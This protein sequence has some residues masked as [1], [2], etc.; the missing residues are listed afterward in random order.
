VREMSE[1]AAERADTVL[2]V[3]PIPDNE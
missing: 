2:D 3:T 1:R